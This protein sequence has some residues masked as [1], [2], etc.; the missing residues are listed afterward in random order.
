MLYSDAGGGTSVRGFEWDDL[1]FDDLRV[2]LERTSSWS[3][4]LSE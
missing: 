4:L 2:V 3:E 1:D